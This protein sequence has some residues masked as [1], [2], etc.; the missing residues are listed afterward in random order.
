MTG[1]LVQKNGRYHM[2]LNIYE[3]KQR[4]RR[5][6]ATGLP[7]QGNRRRAE[8]MLR[9]ALVEM[10]KM[11]ELNPLQ[12]ERC[13]SLF[14]AYIRYWLTFAKRKVDEVTYQGYEI[15]AQTHILP[16]FDTLGVKVKDVTPDILQNYIDEK[17]AHGRKDGKGGLSPRSVRMHK[18]I[19]HQS[20]ELAVKEGLLP[21]NPCKRIILPPSKRYEPK[22]Y[23]VEELNTLLDCIREDDLYPLV[24]VTALYGLRRS[25][26]LGL[27]WDSI[28]FYR[29]L[30]T[31]RRTVSKVTKVVEKDKT[32]TASSY[33]S[34]PLTPDMEA[35]FLEVKAQQDQNRHLFARSYSDSDYVFTWP[36]GHLYSPDYITERFSNLL[37]N[38]RLPHIRFHELRHSCA[39]LLLNEGCTLKDVQEWMGHADIKMTANIYGHL[40]VA[41]KQGIADKIGA[42]LA[43]TAESNCPQVVDA[44]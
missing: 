16:Y 36:D 28:D 10:E 12:A 39:S 3:G 30:I 43:S 15:L 11:P 2:V 1:C 37:K 18:N 31:I 22:F 42:A 7:V 5:W 21:R 26:V 25:E 38:H 40:D 24:K 27:K 6:I 8:Q 4:K 9:N 29:K 41:R 14:S 34:F 44:R 17:S 35:L 23:T 20:L 13:N 33:R 19:I 32:K